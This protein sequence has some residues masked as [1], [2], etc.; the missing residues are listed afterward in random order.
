MAETSS[1]LVQQGGRKRSEF[2]Q[3]TDFC[4]FHMSSLKTSQG[5]ADA[6]ADM[7]DMHATQALRLSSH[8]RTLL[9]ELPTARETRFLRPIIALPSFSRSATVDSGWIPAA[10]P[11]VPGIH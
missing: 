5:K 7:P 11:G 1:A 2:P 6:S 9:V 10:P 3:K 8:W 4:A